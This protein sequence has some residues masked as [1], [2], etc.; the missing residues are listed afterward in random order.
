MACINNFSLP[1]LPHFR[2]CEEFFENK[3]INKIFVRKL[4]LEKK[5]NKEFSGDYFLFEN[6]RIQCKV[7]EGFKLQAQ[8]IEVPYINHSVFLT[9]KYIWEDLTIKIS[10]ED[11]NDLNYERIMSIKDFSIETF[12]NEGSMLQKWNGSG[13]L[14]NIEF[15]YEIYLTFRINHATLTF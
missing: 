12:S 2:E 13:F 1:H 14:T 15:R 9:G 5:N 4:I 11:Y 3:N 6:I 7:V 8:E 10:V